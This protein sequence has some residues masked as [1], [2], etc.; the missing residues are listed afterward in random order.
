[1][2]NYDYIIAGGGCAGLSL[3]YYL[4][5][6]PKL[7]HSTI[8]IIDSEKKNTNDRTWCFWSDQSLP[9]DHLVSHSWSNLVFSD[10][11]GTRDALINPYQYKLIQ[12]IDFYAYMHQSLRQNPNISFRQAYVDGFGEDDISPYVFIQNERIRAKEIFNSCYNKRLV[13]DQGR[14]SHYLLQHFKGWQIKTQQPVFSPEQATLM[15]FRT[16]QKGSARF[17][18][19][20]PFSSTEALVE[21]TIFSSGLLDQT[22]YDNSLEKYISEKLK[23]DQYEISHTEYGV[24]P[25]TDSTFPSKIFPHVHAI[26]TP[27]GAV[28][29]TTGYA[30]LNIQKQTS[31]IVRQIV[32]GLPVDSKLKPTARFQ[33]YDTLL[34]NILSTEGHRAAEIFGKLFHR[35]NMRRILTFLAER[36]NLLQEARIFLS[37]PFGP[38]LRAIGKVYLARPDEIIPDTSISTN[39]K[40]LHG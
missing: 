2:K 40:Q 19:V 38:F 36:S 39:I 11:T 24:I 20:L 12:G 18:Y 26:G 5:Q 33:F 7:K 31:Q 3:A 37:L 35:N 15:D 28:K 8:L 27:S 9:F 21:Y 10:N 14:N 30:F 25:M 29:P 17:F 32:A 4:N 13:T 6:E 16:P 34:L 23:I 1:M 22:D